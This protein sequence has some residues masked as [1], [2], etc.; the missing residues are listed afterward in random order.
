[1]NFIV[2]FFDELTLYELHEI[3]KARAQIFVVEQGCAYQDIDD[4]DYRSLH[5]F[6]KDGD[7]ITSY[8]RLFQK[9]ANT[10]QIG[11]VLTLEHRK[12]FGG[13]LLSTALL[14]IQ[15]RLKPQ[16]IYLEAQTH[17]IGFYE[18]EGFKVCSD[19]FYEDGIPH[20]AMEI[21]L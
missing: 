3:L 10:V 13:E 20:V 8:L 7:T 16:K 21:N 1:M 9:D 17:A 18:R 5:I 12:G 14:E 4:I 2:K 11:R 19:V 6:S 15:K